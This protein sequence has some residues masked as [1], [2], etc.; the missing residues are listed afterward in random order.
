MILP[1]SETGR[2]RSGDDEH[3][4]V[5]FVA[6]ERGLALTYAATCNGWLYEVDPIG[7][8]RQDPGSILAPGV[9]MMCDRA[10]ILRRWKPSRVEV[11]R[12]VALVRAAMGR[13]R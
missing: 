12:R 5:V 2:C 6:A 7:E 3:V 11:D 9:S 13:I 8:V 1:P 4:D 10:R